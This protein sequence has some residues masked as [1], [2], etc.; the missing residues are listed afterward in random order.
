MVIYIYI[1]INIYSIHAPIIE[2]RLSYGASRYEAVKTLAVQAI[3]VSMLPALTQL[4]VMGMINIP[5]M[6]TGQIFAGMRVQEAVIYQEVI[7]FMVSA[8]CGFGV[9]MTVCVSV[10]FPSKY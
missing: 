7:M 3:R 8:S 1:Y 10:F 4:S 2:T 6:M 9:L 5:G